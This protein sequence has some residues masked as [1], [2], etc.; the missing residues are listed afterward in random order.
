MSDCD[1]RD[2]VGRN[3][4]KHE[5]GESMNG[6]L[7]QIVPQRSSCMRQLLDS[8]LG[9]LKLREKRRS[10]T[11]S[12]HIIIGY[13]GLEFLRSLGDNTKR[14]HPIFDLIS[15]ITSFTGRDSVFPAS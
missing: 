1:S 3:A 6:A 2:F 9:I 12:L 15:D 11:G 8:A 14:F 10:E 5:I 13:R 7:S 4:V